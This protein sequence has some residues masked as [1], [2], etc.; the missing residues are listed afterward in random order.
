M[1][2]ILDA[3][4]A[5][6]ELHLRDVG[7]LRRTPK[8]VAPGEKLRWCQRMPPR[9]GADALRARIALRDDRGP[10]LITPLATMP[11][12]REHLKPTNRLRA[13]IVT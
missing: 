5:G 8:L 2:K 13:S 11:R 12:A 9:H 10:R 3:L 4:V 7:G 1:D 6:H